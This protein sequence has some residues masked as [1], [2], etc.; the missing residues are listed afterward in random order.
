MAETKLNM[1]LLLR[2]DNVFTSTYVLEKGEPGF[3]ISTNTLKIGDGVKTWANLPIANKS[4]IDE[5]IKV[6]DDKVVALS[7]T[8]SKLG[9]TYATDA[10]LESVRS[11]L[12]DAKLDKETY[13]TYI[14]SHAMTDEQINAKIDA[15]VNVSDYNV[16]K[17]TFA[18]KSEVQGVDAKF[19]SYNTTAVQ[20]GIDDAQ[21]VRIKAIEDD[22]LVAAD[23]ANMAT[24]SDVAGVSGDLAAYVASNNA[25]VANKVEKEDGKSLISTA[26]I[27]R[28]ANVD[29]Y[30]DTQVKADI[31]TKASTEYVNTELG[32][33]VDKVEG[34]SLVSDDEI[35][36]L[37]E[38][39]NYDDTAVRGLISDNAD[40]IDALDKKVG[41]VPSIEGVT[42]VVDYINKKTDG[43]ATSG[44]LEAL[45]NRVTAVEGDVA[46][47]KGDYLKAA[48]KTE[49]EGKIDLKANASDVA[50]MYTNGQIDGFLAGKVDN[51]TY[52]EDKATFATKEEIKTLGDKADKSYVDEE[53][54]KKVNVA[55]YNNDKATFALKEDFEEFVDGQD[56]LNENFDDRLAELE[57]INH[58]QLA[59]DAAASAVATIRDE[60]PEAFDTLKEI[61]TW[62]ADNET[63]AS[64]A[65]LVTRVKALE[66]ID[67][68]AYKAA[69]EALKT[70]LQK[71]IDSDVKVVADA[72][73][74]AKIDIS[75]EIDS[76][77][78]A[79]IA[80]E[81]TRSDAKA[82]ELADAA[83]EAAATALASAKEELEGSIEDVAGDLAE[84]AEANDAALEAAIEAAA[85][86]ASTKAD[87]ALEAAK[88][89]A[90]Q[91]ISDFNTE[92]V[93][94]IAADVADIKANKAGYATTSEVA[95]AKQEAINAA[96]EYANGLEH[97]DT[98]YSVAATSNAL[99][100]TVTPS[101]GEAQTV[102]LVA[103]VVD[104]GI[105]EVEAGNDIV[106]TK[107]ENGKV[108][109]AHEAF[110]TGAYTKNPADS[111]KTGDVYLMT[112]VTVDNGHVTGANV[113]SLASA[114]MGMTFIFDG[115]NS[116]N[117]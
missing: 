60:A 71:E 117:D 30:D 13:N 3:E 88:T 55:D 100:F 73:A 15:K 70:E 75:A 42:T 108:T 63:A 104:T 112:G 11:A 86:D 85:I 40:A 96:K 29:N 68:E 72:L 91:E 17:A 35:A 1:Q 115:G 114:L 77:V 113:Q 110:T 89:Y 69:D 25:A 23:I 9:D 46:T 98:T 93:A 2:R 34:Y 14:A 38:V 67:H 56:V 59:I 33:K 116:T 36:R 90:D 5:L 21:D 45:G 57:A 105:M 18:T 6:T 52:A 106:V 66:D 39:D 87:A 78:A 95:T 7:E 99:E 107:G 53:L 37:A 54:G 8:V 47:I 79:A 103:P 19:A 22:Y 10:E 102:K 62:I 41:T 49:L 28:L 101:E 76:D 58:E 74:Q 48:D 80:A 31:A 16:D 109:V 4:A 20:K 27:A 50:A 97:K 65:D 51:A 24:T 81:V 82:K 84:Y 12:A 111:D 64:A 32:K 43:I 44:N 26:E 83:A 61:A 94:P 92:V